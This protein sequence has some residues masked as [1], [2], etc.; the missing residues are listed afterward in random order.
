M[1]L[2]VRLYIDGKPEEEWDCIVKHLKETTSKAI[3]PMYMSLIKDKGFIS[4][5]F[6]VN[7]L[8]PIVRFLGESIHKCENVLGTRTLTLIKPVFLPIP[9]DRPEALCRFTVAL[10]VKIKDHH[11]IYNNLLNYKYDNDL[12]G[13]YVSYSLGEWDIL[14]SMLAKGRE[15]ILNFAYKHIISMPGVVDYEIRTI[16][17]SQHLSSEDEWRTLQKSLLHIP[18][19]MSTEEME[20]KYLYD[21]DMKLPDYYA[22]TCAM[23]DEL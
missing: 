15:K 21:Y 23:A 18:R 19:W 4:V 5:I 10:K 8:D 13:S 20:K 11:E 17:K 14:I 2:I 16:S 6:K 9:K 22:L 12:F 1:L 7:R 3:K